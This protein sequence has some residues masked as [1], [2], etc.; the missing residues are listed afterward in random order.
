MEFPG[1]L[2]QQDDLVE[3]RADRRAG[4]RI[5][6]G[7]G[8]GQE[9]L[10]RHPDG[11]RL[12]VDRRRSVEEPAQRIERVAPG[13]A[14]V[15][16]ERLEERDRSRRCP[17]GGVPD[18]AGHRRDV[19]RPPRRQEPAD[20]DVRVLARLE[21]A[22]ELENEPLAEDHRRVALLEPRRRGDEGRR[23]RAAQARRTR[24][25]ATAVSVA[26]AVRHTRPA[27]IAATRCSESAGILMASTRRSASGSA[28]RAQ[29]T[30]RRS[31]PSEAAT[32][33]E[34]RATGTR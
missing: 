28:P 1:P 26:P 7:I 21:A 24:G 8:G 27:P 18:P 17:V 6:R 30:T 20:L 34:T 19:D 9:P 10:D 16:C 22:E 2:P 25:S 5:R 33:R 32:A 3:I 23:R 31:S 14:L 13:I 15:R 12:V 29:T 11:T 4:E